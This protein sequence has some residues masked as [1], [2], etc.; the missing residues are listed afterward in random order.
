PQPSEWK[1]TPTQWQPQPS[2]EKPKSS[3][4]KPAPTKKQPKPAEGKPKPSEWK[5]TPTQWQP[6]PSEEKPKPTEW[7]PAP[8]K[9]QPK[10]EAIPLNDFSVF[11]AR[12][13]A[14]TFPHYQGDKG[15][16]D[17]YSQVTGKKTENL[18]ELPSDTTWVSTLWQVEKENFR[19]LLDE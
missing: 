17:P 14:I 13:E 19:G 3:E 10:P 5:S 2:G 8:T 16:S 15:E 1:P 6:Q 9:K 4:W 12:F 11:F 7:K 18:S